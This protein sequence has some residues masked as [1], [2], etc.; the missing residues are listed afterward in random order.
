ASSDMPGTVQ[1]WNLSVAD[2]LSPLALVL[3]PPGLGSVLSIWQATTGRPANVVTAHQS[4]AMAVA[5]SPGDEGGYLASAGMDGIVRLWDARTFAAI[6][7]L[8]D[9]RGSVHSLAFA[10]D[11]QRLA[12]AGSDGVIRVWEMATRRVVLTLRGH[13]K[14][15]YALAFSPDGKR[16]AWGGWDGTVRVGDVEPSP[17]ARRRAE[18]RK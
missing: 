11:G 17:E 3:P 12:S 18:E 7:S 9:H 6:D 5:F 13:T 2:E 4:R 1:I 8:R 14:A 10:P 16:L 15:I